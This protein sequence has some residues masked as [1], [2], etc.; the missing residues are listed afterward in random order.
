[1][2]SRQFHYFLSLCIPYV[3][4]CLYF[5][6]LKPKFVAKYFRPCTL[7]LRTEPGEASGK[8]ARLHLCHITNRYPRQQW[9]N[10]NLHFSFAFRCIGCCIYHLFF[11]LPVLLCWYYKIQFTHSSLPWM[12]PINIKLWFVYSHSDEKQ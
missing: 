10:C 6:Y 9:M 5:F 3:E 2:V 12:V 1:M 4:N 7:R 8:S 11:C